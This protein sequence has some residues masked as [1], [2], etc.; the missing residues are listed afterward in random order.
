MHRSRLSPARAAVLPGSPTVI[1]AVLQIVFVVVFVV[2]FPI[3]FLA[4][5]SQPTRPDGSNG[6]AELKILAINDFHGNLE[7]R[8]GDLGGASYLATHLRRAEAAAA[9]TVIVSA[10]DLIGATPLIS[11]LFHDEPTIEIANLWGL[12]FNAV[13][14]HEFDEG[15]DEL[16]RMQ[17][18]GAHPV[19]GESPSGPFAGAAFQFLAANVIDDDS[20]DTLLPPYAIEYYAG[21]PVA[22]I[23]LTL[24]GT[25]SVATGTAVAGLSF[26]D[27]ADTINTLVGEIQEQGVEA[28]V[29]IVHEGG[30]PRDGSE[31]DCNDFSGS[32]VD[33]V[34]R[35]DP[36]VDLFVTGHTHRHYLC[37]LNGR[38]VTSTG[39]AGRFYTDINT[40]LDRESGDMTVVSFDNVPVTQDVEPA[41][42]V[43]ALV[44]KYRAFVETVSSSI[45][46][47]IT[48]DFTKRQNESGESSLGGLIADAQLAAT[49]SPEPGAA[50]LAFMN[51]GGIRNDLLFEASGDEKNGEITFAEIFS[52]HPFGNNLVT[53][54]L[55]GARIH[56][57]LEQQWSNRSSQMILM[58]SEGFSYAWSRTAP[59]GARVDPASIHIG[60][61]VVDPS[62][63]YRVTVNNFLAG[64][65]DGFTVL[66]EGTERVDGSVDVDA[67]KNYLASR[68]PLSPVELD[69]IRVLP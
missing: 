60:G 21:I 3:V 12:D 47:T 62:A 44:T 45:V 63:G 10:G 15:S 7:A 26:M 28:I 48:G 6:F 25:P 34:E 24:E 16:L 13:G 59:V 11:G 65:G 61:V 39:T 1:R 55:T 2:V 9:H 43:E 33:I 56:S 52:V 30:V 51:S 57:L 58:P 38:P 50:V 8:R 37:R 31:D 53:M 64:G 41:P 49:V 35:T 40:R 4:A 69:R 20:G 19:D 27:E 67:L 46:G 14:N 54:T 36:A 22:F 23:G 18:G 5:C 17:H 32:I 66:L 68:S 42:D 29:V